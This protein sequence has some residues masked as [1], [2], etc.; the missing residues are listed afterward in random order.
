MRRQHDSREEQVLASRLD[1]GPTTG[2]RVDAVTGAT[3]VFEWQSLEDLNEQVPKAKIGNVPLSR[4]ILGGNLIGG[5]A[6]ARDLIYVSKLVKAYHTRERIFHTLQMAEAGVGTNDIQRIDVRGMPVSEAR[7]PF[8][9]GSG[10]DE[11]TGAIS[12]TPP[13]ACPGRIV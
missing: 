10:A 2:A 6:H 5:W 1:N 7:Y 3:R 11:T 4:V 9:A 8:S 13:R 12:C